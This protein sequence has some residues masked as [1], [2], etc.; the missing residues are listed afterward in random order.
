MWYVTG[1]SYIENVSQFHTLLQPKDVFQELN[2]I[3]EIPKLYYLKANSILKY[4]IYIL[5]FCILLDSFFWFD[6][7]KL[8]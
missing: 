8:G 7:I 6:T 5:T 4:G 1:L 2:H 3:L